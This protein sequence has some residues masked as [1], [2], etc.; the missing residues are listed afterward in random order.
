MPYALSAMLVGSVVAALV[1]I[2]LLALKRIKR[3]D[4]IPMIP[5]LYAGMLVT[6][7]LSR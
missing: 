4:S 6:L 5:F 1:S 2:A 7:F 3:K